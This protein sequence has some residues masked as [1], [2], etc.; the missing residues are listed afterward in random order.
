M[1]SGSIPWLIPP[2]A[3]VAPPV[4]FTMVQPADGNGEPV[5]D[6]PPHRPLLGKLDVVGIRRG[7]AADETGLRG[8]E[9]QVFAIAL[10]H[11][12]ADDGDRLFAEIGLQWLVATAIRFRVFAVRRLQFARTGPALP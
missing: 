1:T 11:R 7:S 9:L 5:A 10:T 3:L 4:E 6:L 8:H 12:L 2:G